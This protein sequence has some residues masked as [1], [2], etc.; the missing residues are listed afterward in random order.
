MNSCYGGFSVHGDVLLQCVRSDSETTTLDGD[1][2]RAD[3]LEISIRPTSVAR[4]PSLEDTPTARVG[5]MSS[6]C[7][8]FCAQFYSKRCPSGVTGCSFFDESDGSDLRKTHR[9]GVQRQRSQ[10]VAPHPLLHLRKRARRSVDPIDREPMRHPVQ[11]RRQIYIANQGWRSR[12]DQEKILDQAAQGTEQID[13]LL[14]PF[15]SGTILFG[16][17]KKLRVIRL[18]QGRPK[19]DQS[20]LTAGEIGFQVQRESSPHRSLRKACHQTTF[21][22]LQLRAPPTEHTL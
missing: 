12:N 7:S 18:L 19:H 1:T 9:H 10:Q 17:L 13:R 22:R 4:F 20:V 16:R 8:R 15:G 21:R 11:L 6:H 5:K 14:L 3:A 2:T